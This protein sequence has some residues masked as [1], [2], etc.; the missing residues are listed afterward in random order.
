MFA[1]LGVAYEDQG[2]L[3]ISLCPGLVDTAEDGQICEYRSLSI[4]RVN[5]SLVIVSSDD[6]ARLQAIN[7]K[8]ESYAP[9]FTASEPKASAES[10]LLAINRSSLE[11]GYGGSF[12]S[13]NGTRR[14]M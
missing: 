13:H 2:I 10:C 12:L 1:K 8:F 3:F 14:W 7:L 6:L 5:C 9:G 4:D 11:E